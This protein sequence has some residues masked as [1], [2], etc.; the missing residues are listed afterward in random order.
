M[1]P[2]DLL[3]LLIDEVDLERI[4]RNAAAIHATDRWSS[5][6][7]YHETADSILTLMRE[8]RLADIRRITTPADGKTIVGDWLM[9]LAWD[10]RA[11]TVTV[12]APRAQAGRVLADYRLEPNHLVRWSAPTKPGGVTAEVVDV[13]DGSRAENYAGSDVKGKIVLTSGF[14][15]NAKALA[16]EHE[17]L[18]ILSDRMP[19]PHPDNDA[20][21]PWHNVFSTQQHWGPAAGEPDL[22]AFTLKPCD[23]RRLRRLISRSRQPVRVHVKVDARLYE[24]TLDTITGRLRGREK[25]REEVWV[26]THVYESGADDNA[27]AAAL[28]QEVLA[29]LGRLIR[30]RRLPPLRRSIRH[31]A[32]WECIGST[33]YLHERRRD[34]RNVVAAVCL[35]CV[36]LQRQVTGQPLQLVV[37]PHAQSSYTDALMLDLWDRYYRL[38]PSTLV[39]ARESPYMRGSD[40]QFCDPVY[41]IPTVWPYATIGRM[42]HNSR[43]VVQRHDPEM[44]R[45]FAA[46]TGAFLYTLASA[47]ADAA[48]RLAS[49]AYTRA[50]QSLGRKL[51]DAGRPGANTCMDAVE[52]LAGRHGEAIRSASELAQ[53]SAKVKRHIDGLLRRMDGWLAEEKQPLAGQIPAALPPR[54]PDYGGKPPLSMTDVGR[55]QRQPDLMLF[56]EVVPSRRNKAVGSPFWLAHLPA[57]QAKRDIG[58][59]N[60]AAFYWMDGRR[61]LAEIDRL[62]THET[63]KP[64]GAGFLR[65]LRHL[66]RHGYLELHWKRPLT[67]PRIVAGLRRMGI[68]RGDVV[69]VH[70]SLSSLGH[71]VG[72]ADGFI[73]GLLDAIGPEGTLA[74]P[75]FTFSERE[76]RDTNPPYHPRRT[77][78]V[79]GIVADAFWRRAEV[80]RSASAGHAVAAIGP[81]ADFVTK[82]EVTT[83]PYSREG[84]FGK[85]YGLDA[86]VLLVG[87]GLAPNVSLHA[88]EDWVGLPGM[89]PV[90][91]LAED[92][93]GKVRTIHYQREPVGPRDFHRSSS[94][95]TKSEVL[96][97]RNGILSDGRVGPAV[98]YAFKFRDLMDHSMAIIRDEDPCFLYRDDAA[99]ADPERSHYF[100]RE[101]RR[102]LRAGEL[103]LQ[104]GL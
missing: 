26:Y 79:V 2:D 41:N 91:Y 101:T 35:D 9:P 66:E 78:S 36:G 13:G 90:D 18:G 29:C 37:N 24:G 75:S 45:I 94:I 46:T 97:R 87:C 14:V 76:R 102:R 34:L 21:V 33:V 84:P 95:V 27:A 70:S 65:L 52:H 74:M 81:Q 28:T 10:G 19:A 104:A 89:Q 11:G 71:V 6:D 7:R 88:V 85:L 69:F 58:L 48:C 68:R 61:H 77:P 80:R 56:P 96:L 22:W 83:E 63:G 42:W 20:A 49:T 64:I 15:G 62:V 98:A 99:D 47:D 92:D 59:L 55:S 103:C 93:D 17:A 72:D 39:R 54:V 25:S 86:K 38:R 73:D 67:R 5:F 53:N 57:E 60:L 23:G 100:C 51:S 40:T 32:G 50:I 82:G 44:Y 8:N 30:Q 12:S 16:L 43:D 4:R 1:G 31:V 3:K